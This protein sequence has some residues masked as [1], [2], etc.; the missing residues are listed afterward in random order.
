MCPE[1]SHSF[2]CFPY[3]PL[4]FLWLPLTSPHS[5]INLLHFFNL[6]WSL[7]S[8]S[9]IWK[10]SSIILMHKMIKPL[11]SSASFWFIS[12]SSYIAKL[13]ECII[14]SRV[15]FFLESNSIFSP[16]QAGFHPGWSTLDLILYLYQSILDGFNKPRLGSWTILA[17]IDFSKAFDSV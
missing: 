8:F 5:G 3:S 1:E 9:S 7:H 12:L 10:T 11:D 15:L 14:L 17:T 2:F 6:S 13:L 4:N 16:C